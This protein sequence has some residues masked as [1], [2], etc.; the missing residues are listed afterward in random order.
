MDGM[1]GHAVFRKWT[2]LGA[3]QAMVVPGG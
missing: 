3:E 1:A 2:Q